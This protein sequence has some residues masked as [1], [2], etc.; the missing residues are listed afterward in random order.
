M[1]LDKLL[2][3]LVGRSSTPS[4]ML[5]NYRQIQKA[6]LQKALISA[7]FRDRWMVFC[8]HVL[9]TRRGQPY[10]LGYHFVGDLDLVGESFQSPKRWRWLPVAYLS[11]VTVRP[12]RWLSG[13]G[14]P[15]ALE[16]FQA[17][18]RAA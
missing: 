16:D 17:E 4:A 2:R 1:F 15:P 6:I 18:V 8:P 3:S 5:E 11:Q 9:G 14:A 13:G 12:G 7:S 10:V